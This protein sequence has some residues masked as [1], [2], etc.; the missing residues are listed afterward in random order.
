MLG[1]VA[2]RSPLQSYSFGE[3]IAFGG[4]L[5]PFRYHHIISDK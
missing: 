4:K 5:C 1:L 3:Y 2:G